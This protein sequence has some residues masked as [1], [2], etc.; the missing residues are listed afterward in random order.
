MN[1]NLMHKYLDIAIE[2]N[3][4]LMHYIVGIVLSFFFWIFIGNFFSWLIVNI[5][6]DSFVQLIFAKDYLAEKI[7]DLFLCF[8][9]FLA[10]KWVHQRKWKT[11]INASGS[12]CFKKL[13]FG[14]LIWS[15]LIVISFIVGFILNSNNR[16]LTFEPHRWWMFLPFAVVFTPIQVLSEELLFR[17]YLLQGISCI[18]R[19]PLLLTIVNSFLF[20]AAHLPIA[21]TSLETVWMT[22]YYFVWGVFLVVVTLKSNGIELALGIHTATNLYGVLF[23]QATNSVIT[24]PTIWKINPAHPKYLVVVQLILITAFCILM[25]YLPARKTRF[26]R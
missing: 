15:T 19:Q 6:T 16:L 18:I 22:L 5:L 8:G 10:T 4:S 24:T 26:I 3:S 13:L 25:F 7:P 9:I 12:I 20:A 14:F 23:V 21:Q 2:G 17:G 1:L 11:L